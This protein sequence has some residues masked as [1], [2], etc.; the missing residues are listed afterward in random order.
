MKTVLPL[1]AVILLVGGGTVMGSGTVN[2]L[3]T[4]LGLTYIGGGGL[5]AITGL[6][7]GKLSLRWS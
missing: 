7:V 5:A 4:K 3:D 2:G 6:I 1:L